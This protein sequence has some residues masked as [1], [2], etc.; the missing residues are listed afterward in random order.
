MLSFPLIAFELT[1]QTTVILLIIVGL[2]VA[3][4]GTLFAVPLAYTGLIVLQ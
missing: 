3:M 1:D 4:V 2:I